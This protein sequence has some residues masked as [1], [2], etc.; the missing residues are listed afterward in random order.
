MSETSGRPLRPVPPGAARP[1]GLRTP[2]VPQSRMVLGAGLA[3]LLKPGNRLLL[4]A[5]AVGVGLLAAALAAPLL[6]ATRAALA[7]L[8]FDGTQAWKL[9]FA[10]LIY[11]VAMLT[12]LHAT[13]RGLGLLGR[14]LRALQQVHARCTELAAAGLALSGPNPFVFGGTA[15]LPGIEQTAT[16]K[17]TG[18]IRDDALARRFDPVNMVVDRVAGDVTQCSTEIRD[19]QQLGVRLG[20]LGTFVGIVVSLGNVSQIVG[21]DVLSNA[22]IQEAIRAI[23]RSLGL[24]FSTS[25]AGLAA[26]IL[27]QL[28]AGSVRRLESDVVE[29]LERVAPRVQHLC[30]RACEDTPLGADIAA[31]KDMLDDQRHV[32]K[33]HA[34]DLL[35]AATR[36]GDTVSL[37][38]TTLGRPLAALEAT[39]L[40]LSA[41]LEA[42]GE[43][44]ATLE[45]MTHAVADLET[46]LAQGFEGALSRASE[47]QRSGFSDMARTLRDVLGEV[48]EEVRAIRPP[49]DRAHLEALFAAHLAALATRLAEQEARAAGRMRQAALVQGAVVA[50]AC[51]GTLIALALAAGLRDGAMGGIIVPWVAGG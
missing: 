24:A 2:L 18:I 5:V 10:G 44:A 50:L 30:R 6:P 36:I 35:K 46:R 51:V 4:A 34:G 1:D 32:M 41:L 16:F 45:R 12:G 38:D 17:M 37:I 48:V 43:A 9:V 20:I 39:G 14:E 28:V 49:D 25:I 23:V 40:R 31:L 47:A 21:A 3:A 7:A 42:Q 29:A 15:R 8:G 13:V 11:G 22:D 27:L 26:A 33:S 19:A